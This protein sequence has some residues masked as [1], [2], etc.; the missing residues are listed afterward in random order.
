MSL[1]V[2]ACPQLAARCWAV[3]SSQ[4]QLLA[5]AWGGR[6]YPDCEGPGQGPLPSPSSSPLQPPGGVHPTPAL[7]GWVLWVTLHLPTAGRGLDPSAGCWGLQGPPHP[8]PAAREPAVPV[9][10]ACA[11]PGRVPSMKGP[12]WA[13]TETQTIPGYEVPAGASPGKP[14]PRSARAPSAQRGPA[15]GMEPG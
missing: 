14:Q 8:G 4:A 11:E 3:G 12:V 1:P 9:T 10:G 15:Q 6:W 7:R 5:I 2:S 13:V